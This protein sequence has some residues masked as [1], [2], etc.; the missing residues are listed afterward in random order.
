M[1]SQIADDIDSRRLPTYYAILMASW[2][3]KKYSDIAEN[4]QYS[5]VYLRQD[6]A[7]KVWEF[8]SKYFGIHISKKTLKSR[9]T[10]I[11]QSTA[12]LQ[13]PNT[14]PAA[15]KNSLSINSP[16]TSL[17][18]FGDIGC[19][20]NDDR[21]FDRTE[22]LHEIFDY[23]SNYWNI[24]LVGARQIGKSSILAKVCRHAPKVLGL[25]SEQII[26]LDMELIH[27]EETFFQR[28]CKEIGI[29][30]CR[31]YDLLEATQGKQ[32]VLCIDEIE[33]MRN[34]SKFSGDEREE[35]R[36][37]SD[38]AH[39]PFTLVTASCTPL[40]ELFPDGQ[41]ATSPFFNIFQQ[42]LATGFSAEVASQFLKKRLEGSSI[43]FTETHIQNLI[44]ESSGHP[45]KLQQLAKVLYLKLSQELGQ[46]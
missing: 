3:G 18:P 1:W 33:K 11:Y 19:I 44:E 23:L 4:I 29:E 17:P 7:P 40:E 31:G 24:S 32:Y 14:T 16:S 42:I 26:Y 5:E 38:G 28:L 12:K 34:P 36:G 45:A 39:M 27:T 2:E 41:Y 20:V 35:L 10:K 25:S 9:V 22:I 13:T 30:Y 15:Y 8:L 37:L 43:Q 21:F 46:M 6:L